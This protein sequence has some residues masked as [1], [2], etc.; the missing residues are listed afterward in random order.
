MHWDFISPE[1]LVLV[2][3][4]FLDPSLQIYYD[5]LTMFNV[6]ISWNLMAE[7]QLSC[8]LTFQTIVENGLFSEYKSIVLIIFI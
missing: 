6:Q 3:I 8:L 7:L 2:L 4:T 5:P 1:R